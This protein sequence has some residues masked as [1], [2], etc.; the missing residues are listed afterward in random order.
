M[1]R[2]TAVPH[3]FAHWEEGWVGECR[4]CSGGCSLQRGRQ[5]RREGTSTYLPGHLSLV[6]ASPVRLD[7]PLVKSLKARRGQA[8]GLAGPRAPCKPPPFSQTTMTWVTTCGPT[9]FKVRLKGEG[10]VVSMLGPQKSLGVS[11]S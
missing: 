6:L 3:V 1:Y 7:R 4:T 9:C 5:G 11:G 8:H 2:I 10:G